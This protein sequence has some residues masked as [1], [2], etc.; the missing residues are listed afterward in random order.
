MVHCKQTGSRFA[1]APALGG[2]ASMKRKRASS[3]S[4]RPASAKRPATRQV[5]R[6]VA[7]QSTEHRI[8]TCPTKAAVLIRKL[9]KELRASK[10]QRKNK[11][12]K[13]KVRLAPQKT[14]KHRKKAR[15]AY[16]GKSALPSGLHP[17]RW[18]I[19]RKE[20]KKR[21]SK[22]EDSREDAE[23]A[24]QWMQERGFLRKPGP[25]QA[26]RKAGGSRHKAGKCGGTLNRYKLKRSP[27][28]VYYGCGLCGART[29]ATE[30]G[31]FRGIKADPDRLK[32]LLQ[33]YA[34]ANPNQAVR[35]VEAASQCSVKIPT[36][37]RVV[38]V[39]RSLEAVAGERL[40]KSL[41]LSGDLEGDAHGLRSCFISKDNPHFATAVKE[42]Q[43]RQ[44]AGS[45]VVKVWKLWVRVAGLGARAGSGG[46]L[47]VAVLPPNLVVTAAAPPPEET[48]EV[49]SSGLLQQTKRGG[50]VLFADGAPAW[51]AAAAEVAPWLLH[52]NVRHKHKE[53]VRDVQTPVGHSSKAGTQSVDQRWRRL[54]DYVPAELATKVEREVNPELY[55]YMWSWVWRHNRNDNVDFESALGR[56]CRDAA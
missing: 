29:L 13:K 33:F 34:R 23:E 52:R 35:A 53:F 18:A 50:S 28:K 15:A 54:D 56:L 44:P 40:S 4:S 7:C 51:K 5:H 14:G 42:A 21:L 38:H 32:R 9:Q 45:R 36:A 10:S 37:S 6:C 41:V 16:S 1:R 30:F 2:D 8:E 26:A 24:V 25:C 49:K 43:A 12:P 46:K 55:G 27:R 20:V 19:V 17:H 47:A 22:G 48:E 3:S 39:L 11:Y 31:P